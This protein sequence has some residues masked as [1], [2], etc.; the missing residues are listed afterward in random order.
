MPDKHA[1]QA[2]GAM[3]A[4]DRARVKPAAL[5]RTDP[6]LVLLLRTRAGQVALELS[7]MPEKSVTTYCSAAIR[8]F[9]ERRSDHPAVSDG[10]LRLPVPHPSYP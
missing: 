3:R 10:P 6:V 7:R 8:L 1:I 4:W 9:A 2:M 5:F